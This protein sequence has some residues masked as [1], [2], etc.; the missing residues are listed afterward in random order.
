MVEY[1][2]IHGANVYEKYEGG[3]TILHYAAIKK[4]TRIISLLLDF[5]LFKKN[6]LSKK[7]KNLLE[8]QQIEDRNKYKE[9]NKFVIG[10]RNPSLRGDLGSSR[11]NSKVYSSDLKIKLARD[12]TV[13]NML[14][15]MIG[16]SEKSIDTTKV[17]ILLFN[18]LDQKSTI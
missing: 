18:Y 5:E 12:R 11:S 14:D 10:A 13:S 17:N 1:L 4:D 6:L 7:E 8:R 9:N 3:K 16:S 2:L 15:A